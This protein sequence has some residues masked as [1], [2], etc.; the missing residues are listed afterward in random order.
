[1]NVGS[2]EEA[3]F[4]SSGNA[5]KDSVMRTERFLEKRRRRER[6]VSFV[7]MMYRGMMSCEHKALHKPH[8]QQSRL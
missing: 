2:E 6:S 3:P 1:M 7:L 4:V 5:A 8:T